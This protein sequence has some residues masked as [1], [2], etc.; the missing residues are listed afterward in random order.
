M[1]SLINST[2][3]KKSGLE[4]LII[5]LKDDHGLEGGSK[6]HSTTEDEKVVPGIEDAEEINTYFTN[7]TNPDRDGEGIEEAEEIAALN[8]A[9]S[10]KKFIPIPKKNDSLGAKVS[11]FSPIFKAAFMYSI[12]SAIE[13]ANS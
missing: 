4:N 9:I 8:L 7:A 2:Y 5:K 13:K 3:G 10:M 1:E 12:P 6:L 11:I